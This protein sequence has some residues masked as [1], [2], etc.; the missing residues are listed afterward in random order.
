MA[1]RIKRLRRLRG[2]KEARRDELTGLLEA[3]GFDR[4]EGSNHTVFTYRDIMIPIPNE[5]LLGA[6]YVRTVV[7]RIDQILSERNGETNGD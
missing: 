3:F 5:R 4:R 7:K 2:K 6:P 1:K